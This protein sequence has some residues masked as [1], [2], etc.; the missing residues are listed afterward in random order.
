M[1]HLKEEERQKINTPATPVTD[2]I[3]II[4]YTD[5]LCC[6]S[7]AMQ[8]QWQK[9]LERL[10]AKPDITYIMGGLLPSW[11]SY[12]DTVNS[13]RKPAQMGPEWMHAKYVSGV[14][15][16][17]RIWITDPPASSFPA[18]IA[19][20]SAEQQSKAFGEKYLC[21]ARQAVM[22]HSLNIARTS[23]LTDLA[24]N[25]ATAEASFDTSLFHAD[26][27]SRG[28]EAF[29]KDWQQTKYLGITR[30]PTLVFKL[31]GRPPVKLTGYQPYENLMKTL[32]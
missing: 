22:Q 21:L 27:N 2:G 6:W 8:P 29:K 24:E 26:L 23:V 4:Y 5:P 16:D 20:K 30:F 28:L 7:W 1:H 18:C 15:I 11:K 32:K 10:G 31:P 17:D 3:K 14:D 19:V 25:L 12:N 13:I 9:F